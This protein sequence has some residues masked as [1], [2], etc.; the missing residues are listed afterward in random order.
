MY[1]SRGITTTYLAEGVDVWKDWDIS[2]DSAGHHRNCSC[3]AQNQK[4]PQNLYACKEKGM[5]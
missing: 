5:H 4:K 3:Y 1:N 2:V